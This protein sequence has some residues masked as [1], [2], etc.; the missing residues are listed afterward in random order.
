MKKT[1]ALCVT[2]LLITGCSFTSININNIDQTFN[3]IASKDY[4]HNY[5]MNGYKYYLP[6]NVI[7]ESTSYNNHILLSNNIKYYMYVDTL[8]YFYKNS[9]IDNQEDVYYFKKLEYNDKLGYIKVVKIEN[10][11]NIVIEYN[12]AKIETMVTFNNIENSIYTMLEI[13]TS[14][15]FNNDIISVQITNENKEFK[16]EIFDIFATEDQ[17]DYEEYIKTYDKY[18]DVEN[19]LKDDDLIDE[20]IIG[21]KE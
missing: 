10:N 19:E 6:T 12:Y 18:D 16:D 5:S 13:I 7:E 8:A 1:L 11:Y 14:I 17:I 9:P 4:F 2:M 3:Q 20:D 15:E 21:K